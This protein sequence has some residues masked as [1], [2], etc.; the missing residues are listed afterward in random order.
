MDTLEKEIANAWRK[1]QGIPG[2]V[3]V[4]GPETL[5][6]GCAAEN[7]VG[8]LEQVYI[9]HGISQNRANLEQEV[10]N[11]HVRPWIVTRDGRAVACAALIDQTDGS[12]EVG[13]AVSIEKGSGA[14]KLAMLT[15]AAH[16]GSQR[17]VAEVRLADD[18]AGIPGS[19]AT[20]RICFGTL[21]LIPHAFLPA[22]GH[23]G[24]S[25]RQEVFAFSAEKVPIHGRPRATA[26]HAITNRDMRG[27]PRRLHLIQDRPVRILQIGDEGGEVAVVASEARESHTGCTLAPVEATDANLSTIKALLAHQFV[28]AGIDRSLGA[29]NLPVIMLATVGLGTPIAPSRP[30]VVLS[31]LLRQEIREVSDEFHRLAQ[32]R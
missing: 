6:P 18:F 9:H 16:K 13:R 19:E 25:F 24:D 2:T 4:H 29:H 21:Q 17:L 14:G 22:F 23:G 32:E 10:T 26:L 3:R 15:A 12:V 27:T 1:V 28:I 8:L 20:Q 5:E 30:S 7:I 11:G 31:T